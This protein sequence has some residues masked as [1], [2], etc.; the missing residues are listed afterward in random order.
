MITQKIICPKCQTEISIDEVLTRDLEK[1]I[2]T[3]LSEKIKEKL[4]A[5]KSLEMEDIKRELREKSEKITEF[6]EKELELREKTRKLEEREGE[7]K[8]EV[9]RQIDEAK[10]KVEE[11]AY[12]KYSE[13]HRLKD[14]E[15]D[16][17]ISDMEKLI[18]DLKRKSQQGSMQT[19]GEV[20]ELDLEE[21]LRHL[22]PYDDITEVKKGELGGDVRQIVKTVKGT[23]C[24]LII[25][26]RK[27]TKAWDEKW[28]SKLKEDLV[29][30]K[31][32]LGVIV[33]EII[34]KG[35]K[36]GLGEKNG[37]WIT[38]M[39][40]VEILATLL[41]KNL[42]DVTREKVTSKN[43]KTDAERIYQYVRS[44]E[45]STQIERM[46]E[47]YQTMMTQISKERAVWER[48]WGMREQ[49]L[50]QLVG[51]VSNIYGTMQAIAG[52]AM[53]QVS[54]LVLESGEEQV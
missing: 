27:R 36:N 28:V 26:E 17:K 2:E 34:P 47:V 38:T 50:K 16:S 22:F 39:E 37:I 20:A 18:E 12:I 49:Q 6:R 7:L 42:Y 53:P 32:H 33:T 43:E 54:S 46:L 23:T 14:R 8:L 45:F 15:K 35:F 24:G 25:W 11:E 3:E 51:G 21:T 13:E 4:N 52:P 29:R 5:E 41:R 1:K 40:F 30:D 48:Q 19:Q 31:A 44:H 9:Q 10:K